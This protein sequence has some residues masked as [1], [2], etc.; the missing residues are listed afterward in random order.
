MEMLYKQGKIKAIGVSNFNRVQLAA[1][2]KYTKVQPAINQIET[3]SFFQQPK[4]RAD[5]HKEKIQMQAWAPLADGRNGI[6]SHPVL[7]E[8][9]KKY[10]KSNAQICL[11]L[12]FQ[13]EIIAIPRTRNKAH[14][15]ENLDIFDFELTQEDI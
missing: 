9:G 7:A 11:R 5:L 2:S 13:R 14:I 15:Q 1:L 8:I 10:G 3:H 4:A 12:H 6:F